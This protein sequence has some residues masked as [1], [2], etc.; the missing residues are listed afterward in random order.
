MG[1]PTIR[2]AI[3]WKIGERLRIYLMIDHSGQQ[4]VRGYYLVVAKVRERLPV[5]CIRDSLIIGKVGSQL[6][7]EKMGCYTRFVAHPITKTTFHS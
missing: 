6:Q 4:I 7:F 5:I 2:L 3:F 1:N